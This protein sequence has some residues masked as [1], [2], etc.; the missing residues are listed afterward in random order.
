MNRRLTFL[1]VQCFWPVFA[2]KFRVSTAASDDALAY[3]TKFLTSSHH[4][5]YLISNLPRLVND[6]VTPDRLAAV[7]VIFI[8][9]CAHV[10]PNLFD[11]QRLV[12]FPA[13]EQKLR[14]AIRNMGN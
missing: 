2:T 5:G 8:R 12:L 14:H 9:S 10:R 4:L 13:M 7:V 1:L 11:H 6:R 3:K